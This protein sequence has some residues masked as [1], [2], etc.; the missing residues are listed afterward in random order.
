M[1]STWNVALGEYDEETMRY[2]FPCED[3]IFGWENS[4]EEINPLTSSENAAGC[5]LSSFPEFP[6]LEDTQFTFGCGETKKPSDSSDG[7]IEED[8]EV[9]E[10]K[11]T[12]DNG[13]FSEESEESLS[14]GIHLLSHKI[15]VPSEVWKSES[16]EK[17]FSQSSSDNKARK[18]LMSYLLERLDISFFQRLY[19]RQTSPD[20]GRGRPRKVKDTN[21]ET[22]WNMVLEK[23]SEK[24]NK[25]KKQRTDAKNASICRD[26]K[27]VVDHMLKY[28]GSKWRYKSTE[29]AD[30]IESYAEAFIVGF[31]PTIY[32]GEE[33]EN[34]VKTFWEFIV[35]AYPETKVKRILSMITEADFLTP[36]ERDIF[37]RQL[38]ER[39]SSSKIHFQS[40]LGQNSCFK[41]I[42][43]KLLS[44][45]D[46]T[47]LK[48]KE[49]Y[50]NTLTSL[51]TPTPSAPSPRAKRH[52]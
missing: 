43:L 11:D 29:G 20:K 5:D 28:I 30:V 17:V 47:S 7:Q 26:A 40:L 35:L 42:F 38:E 44:K 16:D 45:L 13:I 52:S 37:I 12:Q 51:L 32:E 27:R 8:F 3:Q 2:I 4:L 24:A 15:E 36:D 19:A 25:R 18:D 21:V 49:S 48:D 39:K 14:F 22:I 23:L 1:L 34:K 10:L 41:R 31:L 6:N 33:P 9:P 46:Q 50:K